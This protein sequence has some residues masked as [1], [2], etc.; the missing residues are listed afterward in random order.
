MNKHTLPGHW[1]TWHLCVCAESPGQSAPPFLGDGL[2]QRRLL[3]WTPLPQDVEH[4]LQLPQDPQCPSASKLKCSKIHFGYKGAQAAFR[5]WEQI[6]SI[7]NR[8]ILKI[9][10]VGRKANREFKI[11]RFVQHDGK[12]FKH[13]LSSWKVFSI[14]ICFNGNILY[15]C[16]L[17]TNRVWSKAT[18]NIIVSQHYGANHVGRVKRTSDFNIGTRIL[19][20]LSVQI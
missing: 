1:A 10:F 8:S 4:R 17:I 14:G 9:D 2:L 18:T 13:I 7:Y 11:N 20:W 15:T 12:S 19:R 5:T 6:L 16:S 3:V